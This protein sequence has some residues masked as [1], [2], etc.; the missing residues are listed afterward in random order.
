MPS[1]HASVVSALTCSVFLYEQFSNLFYVSLIFSL[2]IIRDAAG[3]RMHVSRQAKKINMLMKSKELTEMLGH[4]VIEIFAGV[5]LGI[6]IAVITF[7]L[8]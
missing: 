8:F 5:V 1:T 2:I 6:I 4:Q 7:K 3:L